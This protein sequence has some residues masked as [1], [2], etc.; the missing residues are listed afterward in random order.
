MKNTP[1]NLARCERGYK[2]KLTKDELSR[3]L[4]C[5]AVK[6]KVTAVTLILTYLISIYVSVLALYLLYLYSAPGIE[7]VIGFIVSVL[8]VTRQMRVLE[9]VVHSGSHYH[10]TANKKVNDI[11]VNILA[12]RPMLSDV[13]PY[14]KFHC[15]HHGC[16]GS[17]KDPCRFRFE[18]MGIKNIDLSTHWKLTKAV[19]RWLPGY[20]REYYRDIGLTFHHVVTFI[21]WHLIVQGF[22]LLIAP[23]FGIIFL[24]MWFVCMFVV[25]PVTRS[26][27][28]VSEHDYERGSTEFET[29]FSNIGWMDRWFFHPAGDAYHLLHHLYPSI[30]WWKQYD[31]HE[32]LM[33]YDTVYRQA[34][35]RT[36][37]LGV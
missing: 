28:E 36:S 9:N 6:S 8:I 37:V 29:T 23:R 21:G 27:A 13:S 22:V 35:H 15:V 31:A 17:E 18:R 19:I 33:A 26:I 5:Y 1:N 20:V 16:Y 32:Y 30:P 10:F 4:R 25:L 2:S 7:I 3:F 24:L 14:R 12:A 34:A 11:L